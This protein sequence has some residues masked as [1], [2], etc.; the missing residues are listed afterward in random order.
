MAQC[1]ASGAMLSALASR[2]LG[3]MYN[4][5]AHVCGL[6]QGPTDGNNHQSAKR[7]QRVPRRAK[8][9]QRVPM[10]LWGNPCTARALRAH[11]AL[12]LDKVLPKE[13]PGTPLPNAPKFRSPKL[14]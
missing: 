9:C 13:P 2:L 12:L 4:S 5:V 3:N 11:C 1:L 10:Y 7:F 6:V 8:G 14:P